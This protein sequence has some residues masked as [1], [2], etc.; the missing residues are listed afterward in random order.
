MQKILNFVVAMAMPFI[1]SLNVSAKEVNQYT[2]AD[3]R[4]AHAASKMPVPEVSPAA[5]VPGN[6]YTATLKDEDMGLMPVPAKH[7]LV[8]H[9][10]STEQFNK[11]VEQ[12]KP[13]LERNGLSI[14]N[15]TYDE[16]GQMGFIQ[17]SSDKG[18][19]I[20]DFIADKMDYDALDNDSVNDVKSQVYNALKNAGLKPVAMLDLNMSIFRPTFR[21]YY[22]TKYNENPNKEIVIRELDLG[23]DD[24]LPL[25]QDRLNI[26]RVD[27]GNQVFHIGPRMNYKWKIG[28]DEKDLAGKIAAYKEYLNENGFEFVGYKIHDLDNPANFGGEVYTLVADIYFFL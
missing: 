16:K 11:F 4:A 24:E 8:S 18:M 1:F 25:V 21:Y 23:Y 12:W 2:A 10:K 6:A 5:F 15:I 19:V 14:E 28:K 13:I 9:A 17:Y 22:L 26:I 3:I 7:N 27:R 20:R